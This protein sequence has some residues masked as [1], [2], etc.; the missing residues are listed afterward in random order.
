MIPS[1]TRGWPAYAAPAS[2]GLFLALQGADQ[3]VAFAWGVLTLG[4]AIAL[5]GDRIDW[6][7][8]PAMLEQGWLALLGACVLSALCSV[9]RTRSLL[10]SVPIVGATLLWLLTV[11][12]NR[13]YAARIAIVVGL[14]IAAATQSV[15]LLVS[16]A[17]HAQAAPADWVRDAGAAWLIVP[18]DIAWFGC[19]LPLFATL[20][21]RPRAALIVSLAAYLLLCV[22][23]RSRTAAVVAGASALTFLLVTSPWG[24]G[25]V[26]IALSV[27][28]AFALTLATLGIASMHARAQLWGAAWSIFL[29]HPL[30]GV[31]IH[32]FVAVYR[33][34]LPPD[35]EW[36]DGRLTPW[37]HNLLL[38]VAAESGLAGIIAGTFL[39]GCLV[40]WFFATRGQ[41]RDPR[42]AAV[43]SAFLGLG[44]L[45]LV[46]ASLL[47]QWLWF[48]G[49]SLCALVLQTGTRVTEQGNEHHAVEQGI[50]DRRVRRASRR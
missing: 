14:A 10:L 36:I 42:W 38:E 43:F 48:F 45:A 31:G 9:D 19:A 2:A 39:C 13:P 47:R 5:L 6:Y 1:R 17:R 8:R 11:R 41:R 40:R 50:A 23:L 12:A 27:A 34:Y 18:N 28:G 15:L 3:T 22:L 16:T 29:D 37:P 44:L 30:T 25:R 49:T 20:T 24:R 7:S 26:S 46:E 35:Y 21:R 32:N 4:G 33:S